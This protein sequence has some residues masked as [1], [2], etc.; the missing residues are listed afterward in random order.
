M[1]SISTKAGNDNE[2]SLVDDSFIGKEIKDIN[3]RAAKIEDRLKQVEDRYW[4]QFTAMEKAI[5]QINSQS[6]WLIQQFG[7]G[8]Q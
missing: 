3:D 2:F 5:Q 7:M 6:T 1:K 4:R 8:G